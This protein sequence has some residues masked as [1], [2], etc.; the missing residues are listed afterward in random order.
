MQNFHPQNFHLNDS[1]P[2]LPLVDYNVS[3]YKNSDRTPKLR[4]SH[5]SGENFYDWQDR[6]RQK[7]HDILGLTNRQK[8]DLD[9]AIEYYEERVDYHTHYEN[10]AHSPVTE[11]IEWRMTFQSEEGYRVPAHLVVPRNKDGNLPEKKLPIAIAVQGHAK[12][13]HKSLGRQKYPS[14]PLTPDYDYAIRAMKEGY[15]VLTMDQ[16]GFGEVGNNKVTGGTQCAMPAVTSMLMERSL[17]G[18]RIWDVMRA[19]D[20]LEA[21]FSAILD[22]NNLMCFGNSG[23]GDTTVHIAATDTRIKHAFPSC[24]IVTDLEIA[25]VIFSCPCGDKEMMH[26]S[27]LFQSAE[28]LAL[29]APRTLMVTHG[30]Y[31]D[32]VPFAGAEE[33][34]KLA[35]KC[36]NAIGAGDKFKF[37]IGPEGHRM[38]ADL[39]WAA[40][41]PHVK[42]SDESADFSQVTH[43][44]PAPCEFRNL[45]FANGTTGIYGN[46]GGWVVYNPAAEFKI[47]YHSG[48]PAVYIKEGTGKNGSNA[49]VFNAGRNIAYQKQTS[50]DKGKYNVSAWLNNTNA[51]KLTVNI[52]VSG[53]KKAAA[54]IER[55]GGWTNIDLSFAVAE[56]QTICLEIECDANDDNAATCC[57]FQIKSVVPAK[58]VQNKAVFKPL[59]MPHSLY[60]SQMRN[61]IPEMRYN[62]NLLFNRWQEEARIKVAEL[63]GMEK[64]TAVTN[65]LLMDKITEY[66]GHYEYN[67]TLQTEPDYRVRCILSIPRAVKK[68]PVAIILQAHGVSVSQED[69]FAFPRYT[70]GDGYA[71]LSIEQ[72]GFTEKVEYCLAAHT[73]NCLLRRTTLANRIWDVRHVITA[74]ETHFAQLVNTNHIVAVGRE[75]GGI[76][77]LYATAL[78]P[79]IIHLVTYSGFCN[80]EDSIATNYQCLCYYVPGIRKYFETSDLAG[81]VAPRR[82]DVISDARIHRKDVVEKSY[83]E[84]RLLFAASGAP[85]NIVLAFDHGV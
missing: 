40:I 68:P 54:E 22:M 78:D 4:Y 70:L 82:F 45:D 5:E 42:W 65:D 63:L 51:E 8:C 3:Q 48:Q 14:D 50:A 27:Y 34:A 69:T 83:E 32:V 16:R 20:M 75:A 7:L 18:D 39:G 25:A 77:A 36:Y 47:H 11:Y 56:N 37:M 60:L 71:T 59:T 13:M 43:L 38:Y 12:G 66:P 57:D 53:H 35:A 26:S 62:G 84:A 64:H 80:M 15:A 49:L 30:K 2:N 41:K 29:V 58:T 21:N 23:G 6:A 79:R 44:I 76:T 19:I 28:K 81:L 74:V 72:R 31:D 33:Q 67:F 52:Y 46:L 9:L 85:A 61:H 17:R 10:T 55:G 73:T 24:G 1:P